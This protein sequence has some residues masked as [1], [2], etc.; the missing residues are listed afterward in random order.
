M[1]TGTQRQNR[2]A[3][4]TGSNVGKAQNTVAAQRIPLSDF[5]A[6]IQRTRFVVKALL[7]CQQRLTRSLPAPRFCIEWYSIV[8]HFLVFTQPAR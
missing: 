2:G 8:A 7:E 4:A 5:R 3:V 6:D 1:P